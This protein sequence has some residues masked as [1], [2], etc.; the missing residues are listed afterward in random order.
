MLPVVDRVT[1][2]YSGS[3]EMLI[4]RDVNSDE[5]ASR[6]ASEQKVRAI[7]TMVFV[8]SQGNEVARIIGSTSEENLKAE[9]DKIE[10]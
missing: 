8:D 2:S 1:P 6:F 10:R 4:Y 7:P 5:G 3:I 9:L